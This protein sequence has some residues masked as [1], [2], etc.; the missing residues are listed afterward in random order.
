MITVTL[1]AMELFL[2]VRHFLYSEC[3]MMCPEYCLGVKTEVLK[4]LI[5]YSYV[6]KLFYF[7]F[8]FLYFISVSA[9]SELLRCAGGPR[10]AFFNVQSH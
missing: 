7:L 6:M 8:S 9:I 3:E 10:G 4:L 5:C 1:D 2:E